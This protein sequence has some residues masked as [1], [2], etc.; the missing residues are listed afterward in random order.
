MTRIIHPGG[1]P[2]IVK[3]NTPMYGARVHVQ[4]EP[5]NGARFVPGFP[6]RLLRRNNSKSRGFG[7]FF[8]L[9]VSFCKSFWCGSG[10]P[11]LERVLP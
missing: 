3:H 1:R 11:G 8:R 7:M 4:P 2:A 5:G 6:G 9:F 10:V